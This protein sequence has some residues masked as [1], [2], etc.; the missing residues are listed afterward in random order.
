MVDMSATLIHHGHVN[1]LRHA[2]NFGEVIV[3]LTTDDQIETCKGYQPELSYADRKAILEAF[4]MVAEVVPTPWLITNKILEEN[5]IDLL[6]HGSD[7]SNSVDP[8]KLR[9]L[10]RTEGV[11]STSLRQRAQANLINIQNQKLLLTPG[12][13]AILNEN[14]AELKPLFG[15]GDSDYQTISRNV[16]N[17][18]KKLS[19]KDEVVVAQG[20][21]TLALEM[22]AKAFVSGKILLLSTG[23]YSDRLIQLLPKNCQV[24]KINY[25]DLNNV[26]GKFDWLL[27][28]Y[29]ETSNA[30]KV[31]LPEI[32][33]KANR[34]GARLYVD[35]TGSIGLEDHH[36]L[37]DVLAFSSCKGLFGLTGACFVAYNHGLPIQKGTEFYSQIETHK[38]H[39][40]TGPYHAM[41]SLNGVMAIHS[42]LKKRVRDSKQAV[43]S[44]Y[45][46]FIK[47]KNHQPM[48][49]TYLSAE[50]LAADDQVVLYQP[51]SNL[52]GSIICHLGEVHKTSVCLLNR[53]HVKPLATSTPSTLY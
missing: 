26:S 34:L 15:R 48:L 18:V 23:Y 35:A 45:A 41:A 21:A 51:R 39:L 33:D 20:S 25:A 6:F 19:G 3:G 43:L 13:A 7:N 27:C 1:L 42:L 47:Q 22:A 49:C 4:E 5:K 8:K 9:V 17:W 2:A 46:H 14:I 31:D 24:T 44:E 37:G 11:S 52:P 12:P 28:A 53:I 40:V 30:F 38:K 29:T 10:P 32:K 50:V 16:L 36:E